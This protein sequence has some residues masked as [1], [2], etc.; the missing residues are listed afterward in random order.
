MEDHFVVHY[1][2]ASFKFICDHCDCT[3]TTYAQKK[4]TNLDHLM[5]IEC[6]ICHVVLPTEEAM[7]KHNN[8]VH[9]PK[10]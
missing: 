10:K 5:E 9:Q 8:S 2:S 7:D 4:H 3:F 6:G 1:A